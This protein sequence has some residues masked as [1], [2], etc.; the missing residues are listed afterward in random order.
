MT[1]PSWLSPEAVGA[2]VATVVVYTAKRITEGIKG[3]PRDLA[4][5]RA[6]AKTRIELNKTI[7]LLLARI[8]A[9]EDRDETWR[10]EYATC[11]E[12]YLLCSMKTIK[13][14]RI[15]ARMQ[16]EIDDCH[17]FHPRPDLE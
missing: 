14:E 9:L 17:R 16:E 8:S 1:W 15:L 5:Q 7:G 13:L 4:D 6:D 2:V 11:R 12:E 10:K 3:R